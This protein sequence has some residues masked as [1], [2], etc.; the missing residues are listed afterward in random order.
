MSVAAPELTEKI[1]GRLRDSVVASFGDFA[2][3]R[4]ESIPVTAQNRFIGK[5]LTAA[6]TLMGDGWL[7]QLVLLVP[8][9][10]GRQLA[11]RVSRV[12]E[13]REPRG[14]D[15]ADAL[16]SL[17]GAVALEF[18]RSFS[19]EKLVTVGMPVVVGG[20]DLSVMFSWGRHFE[21]RM[22]FDSSLGTIWAFIRLS[23][24]NGHASD[25]T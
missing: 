2:G 17:A 23:H 22:A 4:I 19:D 1:E 12:P 16:G 10:S 9:A 21:S 14:A 7:G 6:I 3:L 5:L 24:T 8:E 18:G 11:L 13:G 20:G 25:R 15:L